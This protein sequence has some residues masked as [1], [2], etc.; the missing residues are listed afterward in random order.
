MAGHSHSANIAVRKNAQD[1]ARGKRFTKLMREIY[2]AVKLKGPDPESNPR[3]RAAMAKARANSVPKDNIQRA[4]K[5]GTGTTD[6]KTYEELTMEGYGPGGVAVMARCLTDNRNRTAGEV[7]YA[8]SKHGGNLG[9][10]GCVGYMFQQKGVIEV[11]SDDE[12][13]V[14]MVALDAGAEDVEEFGEGFRVLCEPHTFES[15]LNALTENHLK[16]GI[17]DIKMIPDTM[18][19]I[20]PEEQIKFD[21]MLEQLEDCDDVQQVDHNLERQ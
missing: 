5:K 17:S 13:T 14:M 12:D 2:V 6:G 15:C 10:M 11:L 8:F 20:T 21:K 18:A 1:K 9:T 4:I 19:Q 3:L 7:R 16:L